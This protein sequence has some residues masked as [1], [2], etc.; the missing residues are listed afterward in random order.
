MPRREPLSSFAAEVLKSMQLARSQNN[1]ELIV[2][3]NR[4][5]PKVA[6]KNALRL[7]REKVDLVVED[8]DG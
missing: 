7:A 2:V 4:Y 3:D 5:Q 8:S 6:L 1:V